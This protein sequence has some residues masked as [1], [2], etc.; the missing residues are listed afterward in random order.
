MVSNEYTAFKIQLMELQLWKYELRKAKNSSYVWHFRI[1][2]YET[3][4]ER[5]SKKI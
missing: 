4:E 1:S 5:E 2:I 3:C